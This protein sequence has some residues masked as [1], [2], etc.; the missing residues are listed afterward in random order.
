M[1]ELILYSEVNLICI[2]VLVIIAANIKRAEYSPGRRPQTLIKMIG[3]TVGFHVLDVLGVWV[4]LERPDPS[5]TLIYILS[6]IYFVFFALSAYMWFF[7]SE[8]LHD[9]PFFDEKREQFLLA[10]PILFQA[11]LLV[12]SYFNGCVF[13]VS[14]KTGYARGPLFMIQTAISFSYIA[15]AGIRTRYFAGQNKSAPETADLIAF[16]NY[17]FVNLLCGVV[18]FVFGGFPIMILGSTFSIL[19]LYLHYLRNMISTDA[20]TQIANRRKFLYEVE[21]SAKA[22]KPQEQLYL[23][24]MDVDGFK[25]VND[26][27]GH[28]EGDRILQEFSAALLKFCKRNRCICGRYGGDEFVVVQILK[29]AAKF[30]LHEQIYQM[31]EESKI[32]TCN[33]ERL[34]VSIGY[35]RYEPYESVA[36][37]V[38][39]ADEWMYTAK[40]AKKSGGG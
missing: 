12:F 23:L 30:D 27:Y 25:Q 19:L 7:Y 34:T 14:E 28:V 31:V 21:E 8:I 4:R 33:A 35:A 16:S 26:R 38:L 29:P 36:D 6:A 22:L 20:L 11:V 1:R 9:K 10:I 3:F 32:E 40:Y 15:L 5:P 18:Q 39:R 24:F 13:S 2:A 17:S 37:L